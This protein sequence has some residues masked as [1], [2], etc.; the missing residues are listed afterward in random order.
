MECENTDTP[1]QNGFVA[2]RDY[3]CD[4]WK[5]GKGKVNLWAYLFVGVA[6]VGGLGIWMSI[7]AQCKDWQVQNVLIS[8][9]TCAIPITI[10]ACLDYVFDQQK[11]R[12]LLGFAIVF[13][14]IVLILDVLALAAKATPVAAYLLA[15]LSVVLSWCL[16][17]ISNARNPR[18]DNVGDYL[19]PVGSTDV[20]VSGSKGDFEI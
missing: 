11:G 6:G 3:L 13:A 16:W 5:A 15:I 18:L 12:F 7:F 2:L 8:L 9:V 4:S 10:T 1:L 19:S 17:W 14:F 20:S